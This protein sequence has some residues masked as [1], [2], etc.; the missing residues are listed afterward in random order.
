MT[1]SHPNDRERVTELLGR[2]PM[3]PFSVVHRNRQR[4]VHIKD[5]VRALREIDVHKMV[6]S[7]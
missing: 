5:P 2:P 3:G 6:Y 7:N 1:Y 4:A